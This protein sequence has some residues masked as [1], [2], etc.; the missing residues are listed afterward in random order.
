MSLLFDYKQNCYIFSIL[1]ESFLDGEVLLIEFWVYSEHFLE[2]NDFLGIDYWIT[3]YYLEKLLF[4]S[5]NSL[6]SIL[7]IFL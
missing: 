4:V 6:V 7:E 3:V 1:N 5:L 2:M